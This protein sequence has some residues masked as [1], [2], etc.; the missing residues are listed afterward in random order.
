MHQQRPHHHHWPHSMTERALWAQWSL[1]AVNQF[2]TAKMHTGV[3]PF[4]GLIIQNWPECIL[5]SMHLQIQF[6][7]VSIIGL[8]KVRLLVEVP[9]TFGCH[10]DWLLDGSIVMQ[11]W[12][13]EAS[14][15]FCQAS[16]QGDPKQFRLITCCGPL[17]WSEDELV[18]PCASVQADACLKQ[19]CATSA[20]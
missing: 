19:Q 7:S 3:C 16:D 9:I 20:G 15:A 18:S 5:L 17:V 10:M 14:W 6:F 1:N 4:G 11:L 13:P 12:F 8:T 2:A